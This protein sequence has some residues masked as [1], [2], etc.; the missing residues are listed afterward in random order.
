MDH[1][2]GKFH[3]FSDSI[4]SSI[5]GEDYYALETN[6]DISTIFGIEGLWHS[7][8]NFIGAK[9]SDNSFNDEN[10]TYTFYNGYT[11]F[12]DEIL[13]LFGYNTIINTFETRY[14]EGKLR[15]QFLAYAY[16]NIEQKLGDECAHISADYNEK[17]QTFTYNL[18]EVVNIFSFDTNPVLVK[19]D[20]FEYYI[21]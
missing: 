18:V 7:G 17:D 4:A 16:D 21:W 3:P 1:Q 5:C 20:S 11:T 12:S 6:N 14:V 13:G 8:V 15:Y 9:E 2:Y 10:L 19:E